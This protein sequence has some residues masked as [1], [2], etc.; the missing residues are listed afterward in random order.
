MTT[1]LPSRLANCIGVYLGND[2][3]MTAETNISDL[4][5]DSL[6]LIQLRM[7]LEEEYGVDIDDQQFRQLSTLGDLSQFLAEKSAA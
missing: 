2:D 5:M 7:D 3:T 1:M 6:D 4:A